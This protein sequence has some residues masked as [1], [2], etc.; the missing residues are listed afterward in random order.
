LSPPPSQPLPRTVQWNS[1]LIV[2]VFHMQHLR[3]VTQLIALASVC[4][5]I[6]CS[7]SLQVLQFVFTQMLI[8]LWACASEEGRKLIIFSVLCLIDRKVTCNILWIGYSRKQFLP[9]RDT[10]L[11]ILQEH[12]T[13]NSVMFVKS[14]R[15]DWAVHVAWIGF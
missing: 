2:K 6:N 9:Y 3:R 1:C 13:L 10:F 11:Y 4:L 8:T 15:I 5:L 12:E 7:A 14:I